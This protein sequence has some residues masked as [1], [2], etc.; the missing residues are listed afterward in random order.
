MLIHRF[1]YFKGNT[2]IED[3][4]A[5]VK[6]F[7]GSCDEVWL[8]TIY[9]YPTIETHKA[10]A[11]SL[12]D[13]AKTIRENGIRVSLQ[14][15]NTLG[16]GQYMSELDC[17]GL[18]YEGSKVRNMVGFDGLST[19]YSFCYNDRVFIDYIK[20]CLNEYA[21]LEP[22]CVWIDDDLRF[23]WHDP[24]DVGCFCDDCISTFNKKHGYHFDRKTLVARITDDET[25]RKR[26]IEFMKDSVGNFVE[27]ICESFHKL[28]PNSNFGHQNC[29]ITVP[30]GGNAFIFDRMKKVT[31]KKPCFRPGGGAFH[32][33]C[34]DTYI[35]KYV[36]RA[37]GIAQEGDKVSVIAPET[38]NLPF[39]A[40]G[41][42]SHYGI[43]LET[44]IG[45]A[46]GANAM[47]YS[48]MQTFTESLDYYSETLRLFTEHRNYW[49]TLIELNKDTHQVGMEY[50][51]PK[52]SGSKNIEQGE[53]VQKYFNDWFNPFLYADS[54]SDFIKNN[55]PV[56]FGN[57]QAKVKILKYDCARCLS[58][59]EV[60]ELLKKPCLCDI[61]TFKYLS[62]KYDCFNAT[63]EEISK[64]DCY[65]FGL[66][67][68]SDCIFPDLAN[69]T[70]PQRFLF[71]DFSRIIPKDNDYVALAEFTTNSK[72]LVPNGKYPYGIAECLVRTSQGAQW[73][74]FGGNLWSPVINYNRKI[75]FEKL[76]EYLA[77]EKICVRLLNTTPAVLLPRANKEN[78]ITS[79]SI[80]NCSLDEFDPE[81]VIRNPIGTQFFVMDKTGIKVPVVAKVNGN[82]YTLSLPKL[83]A[84]HI[85]TIIVEK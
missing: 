50:V 39:S 66:K 41:G 24:V 62:K 3:Y 44:S 56:S 81:I 46:G 48:L 33:A 8:S 42:K 70:I 19:K 20:N 71:H 60:V 23:M 26:Y 34:P 72:E 14:L 29:S 57:K 61:G 54:L 32:D 84:Y 13:Y 68:T 76:Y 27:E 58:Q 64:K 31:G 5:S 28:S 79:V 30:T 59:E 4:L 55:F 69:K 1:S 83:Q 16:H 63:F 77:Q 9:G 80:F 45:L 22:D 2:S 15:G 52:S 21:Y 53:T 47:S 85:A 18:V 78:K 7:E 74:V 10:Y 37:M 35:E 67:Y 40:Y 75:F 6:K 43:C 38:E 17:S 65:K 49:K 82:E 73:A 36:L 51:L 12:G 25:V 11:Q